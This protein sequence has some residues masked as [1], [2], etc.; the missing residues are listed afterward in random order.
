MLVMLRDIIFLGV[1]MIGTLGY[2]LFSIILWKK[3]FVFRKQVEIDP[4]S[5]LDLFLFAL[6]QFVRKEILFL[7]Q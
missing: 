5:R 2:E 1:D 6:F 3:N 7:A 4:W